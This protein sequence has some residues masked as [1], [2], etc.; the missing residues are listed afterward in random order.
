MLPYKPLLSNGTTMPGT[1]SRLGTPHIWSDSDT[2]D[3]RACAA[4]HK[5]STECPDT[6]LGRLTA[7][8]SMETAIHIKAQSV[9][10]Q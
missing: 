7:L 6:A 10:L 4:Q 2:A 1:H 3:V 5:S 9:S 8:I